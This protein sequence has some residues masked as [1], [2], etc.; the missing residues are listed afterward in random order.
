MQ[1]LKICMNETLSFKYTV[2]IFIF[3]KF[4]HYES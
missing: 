3:E 1:L 2:Y 4:L